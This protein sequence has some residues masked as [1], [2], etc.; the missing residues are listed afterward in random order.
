LAAKPPVD[1]QDA[2]LAHQPTNL[3]AA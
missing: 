1:S 3:T 2:E